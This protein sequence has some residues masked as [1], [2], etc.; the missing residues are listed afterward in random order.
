MAELKF[1]QNGDR[2]ATVKKVIETNFENINEQVSQL[3][4]KYVLYFTTSQWK[5]G[6]ITIA[7]SEY[8]KLNPCVDLYIKNG[9]GY[10]FV[11]GGYEIKD[12]G[13]ELQSDIAYEGKV[14]IR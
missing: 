7:Y 10:S 6:I 3:S 4:N 5:D 1:W 11:H 2:G 13:I 14:V 12:N 9:T 8:N